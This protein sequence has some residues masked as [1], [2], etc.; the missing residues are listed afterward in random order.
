MKEEIK[1]ESKESKKVKLLKT[2]DRSLNGAQKLIDKGNK[3]ADKGNKAVLKLKV[4][5]KVVTFFMRIALVIFLIT[6]AI[7]SISI[8]R[9]YTSVHEQ[10]QSANQ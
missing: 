7:C 9:T 3:L 1:T 10:S 4:V 6:A 8:Y 5:K 2:A